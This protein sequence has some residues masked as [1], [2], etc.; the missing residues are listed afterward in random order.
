M[1]LT[2][3]CRAVI[4]DMH[5]Q[6]GD[7]QRGRTYEAVDPQGGGGHERQEKDWESRR[8]G[9]GL[10]FGFFAGP[11]EE[12]GRWRR[13]CPLRERL[14]EKEKIIA[15]GKRT[16]SKKHVLLSFVDS[17]FCVMQIRV[18]FGPGLGFL[19]DTMGQRASKLDV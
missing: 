6:A 13:R 10:L 18:W 9:G 4:D 2:F 8:F 17:Q 12:Y 19:V 7:A 1:Y 14:R 5:H 16:C 11:G 3:S 15:Y